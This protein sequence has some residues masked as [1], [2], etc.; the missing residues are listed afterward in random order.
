M[1]GK[2]QGKES[3]LSP[4]IVILLA[5][6]DVSFLVKGNGK[7]QRDFSLTV[8]LLLIAEM[9]LHRGESTVLQRMTLQ[10]LST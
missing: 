3:Y 1:R 7:V 6:S 2:F 5:V 4:F 8:Y 10:P 9:L